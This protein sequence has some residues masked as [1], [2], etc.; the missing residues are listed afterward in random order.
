MREPKLALADVTH[1]LTFDP[2][3]AKALA[4]KQVYDGQVAGGL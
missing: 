2:T 1:V 3:N 4:R